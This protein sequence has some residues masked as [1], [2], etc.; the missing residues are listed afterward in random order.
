M[1][2]GD[3]VVLRGTIKGVTYEEYG[4]PHYLVTL[5]NG[6]E[7]EF[8]KPY[9]ENLQQLDKPEKVKVPQFVAN[10]YEKNKDDFEFNVWDWIAFR[11]EPEK[12]ENKEFNDWINDGEGTPIQILVNMHQFGYEVEKEK[13]YL[14]SMPNTSNHKGHTQI[15]CEKDNNFFWCGEWHPF[16]TKFTYRDLEEAGFEWVCSCPGI[17]VKEVE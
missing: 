14:V 10:W 15:L 8:P 11:N 1:K 3:N 12:L 7:T 6:C 13:R 2:I 17:E 4:F 9:I 5:P 16:R